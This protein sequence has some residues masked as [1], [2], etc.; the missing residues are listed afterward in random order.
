M[1]KLAEEE[2]S[3]HGGN[4]RKQKCKDMKKERGKGQEKRGEVEERKREEYKK[5]DQFK[6]KEKEKVISGESSE[7]H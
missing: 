3:R 4:Y 1:R 7:S 6:G 5:T 2:G